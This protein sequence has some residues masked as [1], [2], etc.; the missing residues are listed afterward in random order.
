MGTVLRGISSSPS[1]ETGSPSECGSTARVEVP[2]QRSAD[3]KAGRCY[4]CTRP[5][6][7]RVETW[8]TELSRAQ[9]LT[10]A[11]ADTSISASLAQL[12]E[13]DSQGLRG[14]SAPVPILRR[15]DEGN[16]LHRRTCH[17]QADPPQPGAWCR[18][19][20]DAND[21]ES[22]PQIPKAVERISPVVGSRPQNERLTVIV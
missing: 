16:R 14:R 13:V 3:S 6:Q 2:D 8:G 7:S 10:A 17:R 20:L 11:I 18:E 12:G 21:L 5:P 9:V 4:R 1:R 15:R 22:I 19:H